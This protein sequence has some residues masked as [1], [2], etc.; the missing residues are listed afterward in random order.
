MFLG[1]VPLVC[2]GAG[3]GVIKLQNRRRRQLRMLQEEL[4]T[5]T[6]S[7]AASVDKMAVKL[8]SFPFKFLLIISSTKLIKMLKASFKLDVK[9]IYQEVSIF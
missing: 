7:S 2:G 1:F 3:Y 9:N 4:K 8:V 6:K 5:G